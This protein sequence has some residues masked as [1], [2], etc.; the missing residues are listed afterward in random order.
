MGD[1]LD[2]ELLALLVC[3]ETHQD[4]ALAPEGEIARL[5]EAIRAGQVL[6]VAGKKVEEPVEGALIR[7]DRAV[8]YPVRDGIPV[9]LV[10]EGLVIHSLNLGDE[11]KAGVHG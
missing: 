8:A 1:M 4:V 10:P 6:T 3:P 5:N 2:P 7:T 9:M 11:I